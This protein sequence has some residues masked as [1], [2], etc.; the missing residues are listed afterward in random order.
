MLADVFAQDILFPRERESS[1]LGAVILGLYALKVIDSLDVG[2]TS[3]SEVY[4]CQAI[5]ANV[6]VYQRIMAIYQQLLPGLQR[7]YG[8]I[9]QL[10]QELSGNPPTQLGN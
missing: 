6:E 9:A 1:G 2:F 4:R 3:L 7:E 5:P 10:Q 8:A